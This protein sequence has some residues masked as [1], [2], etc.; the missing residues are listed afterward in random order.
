MRNRI[1]RICGA[2]MA[3]CI[4]LMALYFILPGSIGGPLSRYNAVFWLETIAI[5]SFG[6]SWLVKGEAILKDE[7]Q[8]APKS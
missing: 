4:V 5:V 7:V 1:Y 8:P 6:I 3:V 2:A